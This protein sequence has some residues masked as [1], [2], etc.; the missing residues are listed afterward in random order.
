MSTTAN[1]IEFPAAQPNCNHCLALFDCPF[2]SHEEGA[3]ARRPTRML[4]EGDHLFRVGD[5]ARGVHVVRSGSVKTYVTTA[6]GG[7]QVLGLHGPGELL[8]IDALEDGRQACNAMALDVTNVCF[9]SLGQIT[10]ACA[11]SKAFCQRLLGTLG[12][13]IRHFETQLV[14]LG[15]R[16]ADQRVA[17]FLVEQVEAHAR[18]RQ[19]THEIM[20]AMPRADIASYLAMAV[21]TVSRVLT[22][23]QETGIV[24]VDRN[25]IRIIN[26]PA[27][28]QAAGMRAEDSTPL[29]D[30]S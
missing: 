19:P 26:E 21:E 4:R 3:A 15:Q 12:H 2:A 9:V 20:L 6:D 5:E 29:S 23:L 24:H 25:L 22:R 16:R 10:D 8:G 1:V 14:V 27:L 11:S 13:R 30:V 7:E 28:R 18:R 17:C